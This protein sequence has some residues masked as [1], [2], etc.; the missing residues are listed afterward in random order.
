MLLAKPLPLFSPMRPLLAMQAL[1]ACRPCD[2]TR[3]LCG[4]AATA[5]EAWGA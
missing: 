1:Q 3:T 5:P 2:D 4:A